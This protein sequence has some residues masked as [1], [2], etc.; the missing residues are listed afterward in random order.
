MREACILV[1][2]TLAPP[3]NPHYPR[4]TWQ[5]GKRLGVLP[6]EEPSKKIVS[7]RYSIMRLQ[8]HSQAPRMHR[9]PI[10]W[11]HSCPLHLGVAIVKPHYAHVFVVAATRRPT[12][13][14]L[15]NSISSSSGLPSR[16]VAGNIPIHSLR[17]KSSQRS[18]VDLWT[19]PWTKSIWCPDFPWRVCW[20]TFVWHV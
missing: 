6:C 5:R 19:C 13:H 16:R 9:H 18:P 7:L 8:H 15:L 20:R 2:A 10:A 14:A 17:V 1:Y 3:N 4:C 11:R 12:M